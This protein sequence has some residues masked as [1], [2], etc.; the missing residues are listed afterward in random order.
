MKDILKMV[1]LFDRAMD[2]GS[3]YI[4]DKDKAMAVRAEVEM[5]RLQ[6]AIAMAS[7]TTIPWVDALVKLVTVFAQLIRPLGTFAM[8]AFGAYAHM[9]GLG[10]DPML[11]GIFDG[12]FPSW[13]I[14]RHVEKNRRVEAEVKYAAQS[15]STTV[16]V[17]PAPTQRTPTPTRRKRT[18]ARSKP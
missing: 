10:I 2:L 11:H 5:A 13:G 8:S 14:S 16:N 7:T 1:G 4:L 6:M 3:E 9:K 15:P 12:S 17:T 18:G